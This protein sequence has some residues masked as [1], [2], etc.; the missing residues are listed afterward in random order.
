MRVDYVVVGG[1]ITGVCTAYHLARSGG[2]VLL[3]ERDQLAPPAP[4]SSSGEYAKAFRCAYGRDRRM[5]RLCL[6]SI[7][8][9][10]QFEQET[11]C[12]LLVPS[13][14]VVFGADQPS[15]L[16][17]WTNQEAARF[18]ADSRDTLHDEGL[19]H[20]FL[21][22]QELVSR[23]PQI[24]A[25][26]FYDHAILDRTAGFVHAQTAVR[27]I[28]RLA[29]S[30]G[31]TI[32]EQTAV[33]GCVKDGSRVER[34][35]TT[36]GDVIPAVAVVFAAGYMNGTLA[37][38]L[39]PKTKVTRQQVLYLEPADPAPFEPS[40]FPIVVNVNQWR[41]VFPVHGPGI[42]KVAD[43]DKFPKDKEIDPREE[44][45][46]KADDWF[47]EDARD[48]LRTFVPGLAAANEVDSITCRYTNTVNDNYLIYKLANT[49]VLSACSGHGFKNAPMTSLM[50]ASL[51]D[52]RNES[53]H[54]TAEFGYEHAASF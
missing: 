38:E 33:T 22:R 23:F 18:A 36:R 26:D 12:E 9:W 25:N 48:F 24:A 2:D 6:E 44:G 7:Q 43:D 40:R 13:G 42:M 41:Y 17:H 32:W 21:S 37:P 47:R 10:R 3:I 51:A 30:A 16:R 8:R 52:G 28:G 35:I 45:R 34:L 15:T 5:T 50:A 11:G 4:R 31:T 27:E 54:L 46:T 19:P 14:M 20:E 39:L 49:V 53:H 29:A 1:G